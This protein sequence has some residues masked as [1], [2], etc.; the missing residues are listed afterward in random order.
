[1]A[2][3]KST[4]LGISWERTPELGLMVNIT[5]GNFATVKLCVHKTTGERYAIKIIDKKKFS[6][7]NAT[8]RENALMDEVK[9][10]EQLKHPNVYPTPS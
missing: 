4:P 6:L 10:L 3:R 7:S 1:M 8:K 5:R 9:I 2:L